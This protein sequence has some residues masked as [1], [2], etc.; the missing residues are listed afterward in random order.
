MDDTSHIALN[1]CPICLNGCRKG[2]INPRRALQ[3]HMRKSKDKAHV[4][5]RDAGNYKKHFIHGGNKQQVEPC[6]ADVI[7][8]IKCTFGEQWSSRIVITGL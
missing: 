1:Q 4:M 8:A 6:E 2:L 3:E 5:W 7:A